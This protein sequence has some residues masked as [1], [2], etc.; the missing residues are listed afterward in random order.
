[1]QLSSAPKGR[2]GAS[3]KKTENNQ[4]RYT[5]I[6]KM[7]SEIM[8]Y[9]VLG[10]ISVTF[11][12]CICCASRNVAPARNVAPEPDAA[13][14]D[15]LERRLASLRR[16]WN[17]WRKIIPCLIYVNVFTDE[18][19]QKCAGSL[20]LYSGKQATCDCNRTW[21]F[22]LVLTGFLHLQPTK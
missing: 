19:F 11:T 20:M 8:L 15:D 18:L 1:M 4:A 10:L 2:I 22:H 5:I 13:E 17:C 16:I 7:S 14:V 6:A 9:A 3:N 12:W 21:I